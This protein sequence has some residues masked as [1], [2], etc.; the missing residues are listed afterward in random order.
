[1]TLTGSFRGHESENDPYRLNGCSWV[2]G[3]MN[4]NVQ[5]CPINKSA[6]C[7]LTLIHLYGSFQGHES[8]SG[9]YRQNGCSEAQGAYEQKCSALTS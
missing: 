4:K 2:Q 1:M 8:E 5:H 3:A 7:P 9:P 6:S